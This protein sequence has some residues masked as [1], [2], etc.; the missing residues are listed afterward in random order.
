MTYFFDG[1]PSD[2]PYIEMIWHGRTASQYAPICPADVR[3]NLL[4]A[5]RSGALHVSVEGATTQHVP[6]F[7]PDEQEF[8]VIK[9]KLGVFM[10]HLAISKLV[11]G[12]ALLPTGASHSFC[13]RGS[14]WQ[15]PDYENVET[16]VDRLVRDDVLVRDPIVDEVLRNQP[17][18]MSFRT[19]RRRFLRATGL[20]HKAIQQIERAK[21][22]AALLEQG[23]SILDTVYLAGYADQSHM[24]RSLRRY[25]GQTPAQIAREPEMLSTLFKTDDLELDYDTNVRLT[26]QR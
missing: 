25:I 10:P 18:Y 6:K 22:A 2:S 24:T 23:V 15:L 8:L 20:T 5:R 12:D 1:R 7:Q 26:A 9:F 21:R 13:L 14:T 19:V 11:N 16:F 3:W 4:F 17:Q